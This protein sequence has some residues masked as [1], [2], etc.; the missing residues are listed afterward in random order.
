[1]DREFTNSEEYEEVEID[2]DKTTSGGEEEDS[3]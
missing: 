2:L 3:E 1:M